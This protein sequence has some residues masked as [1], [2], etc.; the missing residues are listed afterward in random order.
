MAYDV[1]MP[2]RKS[3]GRQVSWTLAANTL[4]GGCNLLLLVVLNKFGSAAEVGRYG[5][6]L[7]VTAPI[8]MCANLRFA[9]V[10]ASDM[11]DSV[12]LKDYFTVRIALVIAS[13]VAVATML[14][15]QSSNDTAIL[16]GI[17]AVT[18]AI[19]AIQDLC[20]GVQQRIERIDRIAI[21]LATNGLS[22]F[23]AF[24]AVYALTLNLCAA[25]SSLLL[26]RVC[27]LLVYD[28]PVAALAGRE[29]VFVRDAENSGE[30]PYFRSETW[31]RLRSLL[32]A[33]APLGLTAALMSLAS[34]M[35][36]YVIPAAFDEELLGIF[37]SMAVVL[38]AGG[39]VFRA[40]EQP[41]IPRLALAI[42]H[43]DGKRFWT[44]LGSLCLIFSAI[45]LVGACGSWLAGGHL[46]NVMFTRQFLM[47]GGVLASM[48]LAT[49]V[50]QI[51]GMVESSMIAARVIGV[52]VPMHC[53]TVATCFAL[54]NLLIPR[55]ELYGAVLA[56]AICRI[57]FML[58]G[59]LLLRR[60][61]SHGQVEADR[62]QILNVDKSAD[63][64]ATGELNEMK[65][66]VMGDVTDRAA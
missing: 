20:C 5:L 58:I 27:V 24:A 40:V 10:L 52:Q 49:V 17:V 63:L 13:L 42:H 37:V 51:A 56:L 22:M 39:L 62:M 59:V 48:M 2:G 7:A 19:E 36:R 21:S 31:K 16:I 47:M 3:L 14:V 50:G 45:G 38:Q 43:H 66:G 6:A 61:L 32:A 65:S 57:P 64:V 44:L 11:R 53:I 34:N 60:K 8:F 9:T 46:L 28:L 29:P 15:M 23:G 25:A 41:A 26:A 4:Y 54:S 30:L 1:G 18:K 55:L 12:Y 33:S 35:P